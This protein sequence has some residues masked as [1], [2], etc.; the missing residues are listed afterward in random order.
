M[1]L[2]SK[3]AFE[4]PRGRF[5]IPF[6]S[7]AGCPRETGHK[8]WRFKSTKPLTIYFTMLHITFGFSLVK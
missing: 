3:T 4:Y 7:Q 6:R 8:K 5:G 1:Q 2:G